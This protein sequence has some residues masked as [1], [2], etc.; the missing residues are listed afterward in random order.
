MDPREKVKEVERDVT[1]KSI[2]YVSAAL[3]LV[4][5]LAWNDAITALINKLFPLAKDAV[6]M[7]FVYAILVTV[8]VV[9]L[10]QYLERLTNKKEGA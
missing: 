7:K 2:G 9:I 8:A 1:G 5:G 10:I 6:P 3:G 4:A